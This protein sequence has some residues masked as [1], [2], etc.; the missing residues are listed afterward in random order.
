MTIEKLVEGNLRFIK[1]HDKVFMDGLIHGQMPHSV[2][3]TC[4]DSR[5]SPEL[6]FDQ[7]FGEIFVI[8]SAGNTIDENAIAS[9]QYA[10][11]HLKVPLVVVLGHED[12][13]AVNAA[14][15]SGE[16]HPKELEGLLSKI[17]SHLA[18]CK[19]GEETRANVDAVVRE[20]KDRLQ[21]R[22][23]K[24]VGAIYS[25]KTRRVEF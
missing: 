22:S 3:V 11:D 21:E 17:R 5:V 13:G 4:S 19:A 14:L 1:G 9:I 10:V 2:I 24:V 6:I 23:V 18:G 20:I 7:N 16:R 8:R 15:F 12:C 25:L